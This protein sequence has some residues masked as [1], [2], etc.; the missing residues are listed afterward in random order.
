MSYN[1]VISSKVIKT[2]NAGGK[3]I[4]VKYATKTSSWE[5]SFLAQGVQD[6]FCEAVKKAPDVPASAAI[7]ILAEKE[8]PSESDSKSHF[9]TV[10]EDS[11]GNHITTKHV[12]P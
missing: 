5:R 7:A 1:K 2:V 12:Y 4:Q 10:F 3:A 6:E 8:H 9:T 11:N